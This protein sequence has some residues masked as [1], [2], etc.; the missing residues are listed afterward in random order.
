MIVSIHQPNFFPWIGYFDKINRSDKF[1]FLTDS[2]RSKND[3]YL[4][5][6]KILNNN[7]KPQYLSIPLG[8][9][10]IPINQLMMPA[11]ISFPS[12]TLGENSIWVPDLMHYNVAE[13]PMA[14]FEQ[15]DYFNDL[16]KRLAKYRDLHGK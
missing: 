14:K 16:S 15:T 2:L 6:T 3:K 5:R 13:K 9:K 4:T 1:I 10:Q 12:V 7:F 11:E 8:I